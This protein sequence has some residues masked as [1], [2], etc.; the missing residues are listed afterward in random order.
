VV[1]RLSLRQGN[2]LQHSVR[3]LIDA[4]RRLPHWQ[5]CIRIR[6]RL[7]ARRT[8]WITFCKPV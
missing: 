6:I 4:Y 2:S 8:G 1:K 7:P 5:E 3:L